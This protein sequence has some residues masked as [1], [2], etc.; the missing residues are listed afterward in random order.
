MNGVIV[1]NKPKGITSRDV[2]NKL[3]KVFGTKSIGHIC[4][5][6]VVCKLKLI[7]WDAESAILNVVRAKNVSLASN[8]PFK[9]PSLKIFND[10][11]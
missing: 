6:W 3:V 2:V 1:V 9:F 4:P 11:D 8:M 10:G 7:V 5:V